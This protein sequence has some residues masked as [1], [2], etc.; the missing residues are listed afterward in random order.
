[1]GISIFF[2][3]IALISLKSADALCRPLQYI[4]IWLKVDSKLETERCQITEKMPY[5]NN[6]IIKRKKV[7]IFFSTLCKNENW[8]KIIYN[9]NNYIK[10]K[11]K[12]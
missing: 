1:M 5:Y 10:S 2:Q 9:K 6:L 7:V 12:G 11:T 3:V 8:S 4:A